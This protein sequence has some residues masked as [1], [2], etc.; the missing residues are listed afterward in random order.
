MK[1]ETW[2][3]PDYEPYDRRPSFLKSV[4]RSVSGPAALTA[5]VV[6]GA[7]VIYA[8][9]DAPAPL[10]PHTQIEAAAPAFP[11]EHY[12]ASLG[13][14][15][16]VVAVNP[17]GDLV[18]PSYSTGTTAQSFAQS[19]PLRPGF[20]SNAT[21]A[22]V[23]NLDANKV[24]AVPPTPEVAQL[25]QN[26]P[27]PAR[28]PAD[29]LANLEP[30]APSHPAA[31]N[32]TAYAAP[33]PASDSSPSFFQKLFGMSPSSGQALA[34]AAPEDGALRTPVITPSQ[35]SQA[36]SPASYDRTT[37]VYDIS[38]RTVYLPN[39]TKLEA[40]SGLGAMI[41]DPRFVNERMR[42]ATPPHVYELTLREQLF[43][44]VQALRLT[45]IGEGTV[46]GRTGLLAHRYMLGPNGDSNGCVSIKD[47]DAF[48]RAYQN[49]EIR[50][51]VVVARMN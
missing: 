47:Y 31:Q 26:A 14:L 41:D 15:V 12:E 30:R 38:K 18:N 3:P 11:Q 13:V 19:A 34:Y 10:S 24:V 2:T 28:R 32:K 8:H 27:L 5:S 46:Y 16:P 20:E 51:L 29:L 25:F 22:P 40:H 49:G 50:R 9:L 4:L 7:W 36:S 42:G 44:G 48:L 21:P 1:Y 45:P 37:A 33:A 17:Y 6:L 39:G 35:Q 43:H 23:A